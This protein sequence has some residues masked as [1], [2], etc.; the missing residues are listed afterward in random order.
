M[1]GTTAAVPMWQERISQYGAIIVSCLVLAIF[2][3]AIC[4]A[5]WTKATSLQG[6]LG[7]AGTN[8]SVAGQKGAGA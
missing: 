2:Q 6:L 3:A 8:A 7:M 4:I 5:W 1:S